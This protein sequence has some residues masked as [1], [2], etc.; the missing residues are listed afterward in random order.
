MNSRTKKFKKQITTLTLKQ[1]PK[2]NP[3]AATSKSESKAKKSH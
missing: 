3:R 2:V 1:A